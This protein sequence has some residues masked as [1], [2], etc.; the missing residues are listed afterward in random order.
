MSKTFDRYY[1]SAT[2]EA[3]A[4]FAGIDWE[5]E[6][7]LPAPFN[8]ASI[9]YWSL[10]RLLDSCDR[11]GASSSSSTTTTSSTGA[12][13]EVSD[14]DASLLWDA[15]K[16]DEVLAV[17]D[18]EGNKGL[19]IL[20]LGD[21]PGGTADLEE[22]KDSIADTLQTQFGDYE[23]TGTLID[24]AVKA[25]TKVLKGRAG[26]DLRTPARPGGAGA[27][28][29][30]DASQGQGRGVAG[31][32][33]TPSGCL[34]RARD[35]PEA[36]ADE[37]RVDAAEGLDANARSHELEHEAHLG[38][39]VV[40]RAEGVAESADR[41]EAATG[42]PLL[43]AVGRPARVG[44]QVAGWELGVHGAAVL[45]REVRLERAQRVALQRALQRI[46]STLA[47][48]AWH[49]AGERAAAATHSPQAVVERVAKQPGD[50]LHDARCGTHQP[51]GQQIG[52]SWARRGPDA[53]AVDI[54]EACGACDVEVRAQLE[55]ELVPM[56]DLSLVP[57][58]QRPHLLQPPPL[59]TL[60]VAHRRWIAISVLHRCH[61]A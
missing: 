19:R 49:R 53:L 25:L 14:K 28:S 46:A 16:S 6:T 30:D 23:D 38:R 18:D 17:D 44:R 45:P 27:A 32:L 33:R 60:R 31:I 5:G 21:K 24:N 13:P 3:A 15:L 59:P 7:N 61:V 37:S 47:P 48:E 50:A 12:Q 1:D 8:I 35:L 20:R 34:G 26:G 22:L 4:Q 52:A 54:G 56:V 40:P 36:V 39:E 51:V 29:G 10:R 2:Q 9:P 41:V 43:P 58:Q 57:P 55:D 11:S 42:A